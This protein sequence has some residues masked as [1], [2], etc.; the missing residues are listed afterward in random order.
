MGVFSVFMSGLLP[1]VVESS[2]VKND[3]SSLVSCW[4][5]L[6]AWQ[7]EIKK[8]SEIQHK[9]GTKKKSK[10]K[11]ER[12]RKE[13]SVLNSGKALSVSVNEAQFG[14]SSTSGSMLEER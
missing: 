2:T 8:S 1:V 3:S 5:R 13:I 12:E 10:T 6:Q 11:R 14:S 4:H 9:T 7:K